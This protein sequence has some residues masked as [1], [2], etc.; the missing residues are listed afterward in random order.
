MEKTLVK[1]LEWA[2]L[3]NPEIHLCYS[4]DGKPGLLLEGKN[5]WD[6][7]QEVNLE[8]Y[9]GMELLREIIASEARE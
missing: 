8:I 5:E 3:R 4:E 2:R 1:K 6:E 7:T 9:G